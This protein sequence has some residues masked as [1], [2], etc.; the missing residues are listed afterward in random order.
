MC[1]SERTGH[2]P[3]DVRVDACDE[4]CEGAAHRG[5][6]PRPKLAHVVPWPEQPRLPGMKNAIDKTIYLLLCA[7]PACA[8]NCG[9]GPFGAE[10]RFSPRLPRASS[11]NVQPNSC[12][13]RKLHTD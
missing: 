9:H 12:R 13:L 2:P 8:P 6:S 5:D 10:E 4:G 3:A 1:M 7:A 11:E